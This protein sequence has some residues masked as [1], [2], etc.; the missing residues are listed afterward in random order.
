M[1]RL[2]CYYVALSPSGESYFYKEVYQSDL[3]VSDAAKAIKEVQ[4]EEIQDT[5]APG[6]LWNRRQ[7]TGASAMELFYRNGV[8]LTKANNNRI[9]G[10]LSVKE[11]LKP[12]KNEFGE[13]K[14]KMY[15]FSTC[16]NLS[17]CLPQLQHDKKNPND[18]ANDPHELT[19]GP[20][21]VRYYFSGRAEERSV[22][23]KEES[24]DEYDSFINYG[25]QIWK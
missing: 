15:I 9:Q 18:V 10:W 11:A 21:A 23:R 25:R 6:D 17:R 22:P 3:I 12:Q 14:P 24:Y 20:D 4:N 1:D 16:T 19:H 8:P 13:L 7:E 5:F 2:A